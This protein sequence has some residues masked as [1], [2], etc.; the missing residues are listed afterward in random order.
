MLTRY[1]LLV[2]NCK[3]HRSVVKKFII[4]NNILPYVC[5]K[6]KNI[7]EWFGEELVLQL[8]HKNGK[9]NDNRPHNLCFLCPNCHSQTSTYAGK[10]IKKIFTCLKCENIISKKN[11]NGIC[12]ECISNKGF[13][14]TKEELEK[15]L[16]ECPLTKISKLYNVSRNKIK[17][18]CDDFQIEIPNLPK[19]YWKLK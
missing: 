7:G 10:N 12:K 19:S 9:N 15:L 11:K 17:R 4:D 1:D 8:E 16:L 2:E 18:K 3:H 5:D 14:I 6:C 13:E